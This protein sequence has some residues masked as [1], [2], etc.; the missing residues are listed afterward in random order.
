MSMLLVVCCYNN[1]DA[2]QCTYSS[3]VELL[4]VLLVRLGFRSFISCYVCRGGEVCSEKGVVL[5]G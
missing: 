5:Y 4:Y 1:K 2:L 3:R